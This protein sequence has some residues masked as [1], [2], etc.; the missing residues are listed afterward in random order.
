MS[1]RT[2][3]PRKRKPPARRRCDSCGGPTHVLAMFAPAGLTIVRCADCTGPP[4]PPIFP[5]EEPAAAQA[6]LLEPTE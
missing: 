1:R 6:S 4:T 3:K 2:S 5:D